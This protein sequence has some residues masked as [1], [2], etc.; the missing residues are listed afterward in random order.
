M[1]GHVRKRRTWEFIVD[2]GQHP[3]TGRRRQKSKGGFRTKKE[4][5]SAVHAFIRFMEGGGNPTPERIR[6]APYLRRWLEYQRIRGIRPRT[7][8]AYEGYIR[9]EI[10][11]V[12]G[13]LDLAN[14]G[15][16]HIRTVLTR[17]QQRG[18][19]AATIA[20]VRSVLGSAFRQA[21][22]DGLLSTNPVSSVKRP[23]LAT[24]RSPVAY[25][26]GARSLGTYLRGQPLGGPHSL[27]GCHRG[28]PLGDS[29]HLL[30]GCRP[31]TGHDLHPSGGSVTG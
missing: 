12:I 29:R 9:R 2:V 4:A 14:V 28:P 20:Q 11:P 1:K 18:L 7:L 16:S 25:R 21:V 15:P 22:E 30:A 6:L 24:P 23:K 3:V 26:G 8:K 31:R 10:L 27:G 5:E 17:M 13:G 19:A